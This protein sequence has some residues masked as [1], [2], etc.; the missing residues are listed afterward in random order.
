MTSTKSECHS[1]SNKD[2]VYSIE[3]AKKHNIPYVVV[4]LLCQWENV[5][6]GS[7]FPTALNTPHFPLIFKF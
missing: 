7:S 3:R 2:G 6:L 1:P 5:N 4:D